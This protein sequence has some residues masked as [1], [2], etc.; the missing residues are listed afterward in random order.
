MVWSKKGGMRK[1]KGGA[2]KG[3]AQQRRGRSKY[4]E[5]EVASLTEVVPTTLQF[6]NTTLSSYNLSLAS[7]TRAI[8]VAKGYQFYR[9]RRV[10][11]L[12]KPLKDTF[13]GGSGGPTESSIPY[14][15]Y[16]IDRTRLFQAGFSVDQLKA[17]GAKARRLDDKTIMFSYT[18]SVLTETFDNTALANQAVQYKLSP[19]LPTRDINSASVWNPNTTDHQ[20]IAWV[21][22]TLFGDPLRYS[23]ERRVQVEFK[24]PAIPI[25]IES[26]SVPPVDF[27]AVGQQQV[28][29]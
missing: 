3:K 20:G 12:I 2:R 15:Y 25:L 23:I 11:F 27:D 5:K 19:W 17:M 14:L 21:V 26:T 10:T 8:D 13:V 29:P 16:M 6:S 9:I 28:S 4:E 18:P 1:G 22:E 24:K 7:L